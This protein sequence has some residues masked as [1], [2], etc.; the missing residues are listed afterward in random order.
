VNS[1]Q[2]QDLIINREKKKTQEQQER[3]AQSR[4]TATFNLALGNEKDAFSRELIA[5]KPSVLRFS[6]EIFLRVFHEVSGQRP[7]YLSVLE[8]RQ[9][10]FNPM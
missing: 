5:T 9:Y 1:F 2:Q 6:D 3:P 8:G 7:N 10:S 4:S